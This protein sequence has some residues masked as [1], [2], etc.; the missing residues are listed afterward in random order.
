M[1]DE[2]GFEDQRPTGQIVREEERR[3]EA[4]RR[5]DPAPDLRDVSGAGTVSEKIER[6]MV[7]GGHGHSG[8]LELELEQIEKESERETKR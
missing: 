4:R 2:E 6:E 3:V 5:G 8:E 7:A 1:A